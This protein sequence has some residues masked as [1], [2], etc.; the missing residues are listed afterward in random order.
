[1]RQLCVIITLLALLSTSF[2]AAP[3]LIVPPQP[4]QLTPVEI[5]WTAVPTS[6][7][8]GCAETIWLDML[9]FSNGGTART[10]TVSDAQ[11][12]PIPVFNAVQLNPNQVTVLAV[13]TGGMRMD[14]GFTL[15]ASGSGVA[16]QFRGKV[17]R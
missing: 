2:G 17:R 11:G 10:V 7:D 3:P 1:M 14:G 4:N 5:K 16:Y 12:T 9:A 8:T 6:T 15:S 13:P